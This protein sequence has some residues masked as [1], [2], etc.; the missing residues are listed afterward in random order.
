M[1]VTVVNFYVVSGGVPTAED[2]VMAIEDLNRLYA[3][4]SG[5]EGKRADEKM[6]VVNKK[7]E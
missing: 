5:G 3:A 7:E 1:T 6:G 2:V 4:C